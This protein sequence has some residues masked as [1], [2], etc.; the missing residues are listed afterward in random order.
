MI[1]GQYHLLL[2]FSKLLPGFPFSCLEFLDSVI[3]PVVKVIFLKWKLNHIIFL[4][5]TLHGTLVVLEKQF[6]LSF[7]LTFYFILGYSQLTI[8]NVVVSGEQ[9]SE[10]PI[11]IYSSFLRS[12]VGSL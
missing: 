8:E 9:P 1:T 4:L 2:E 3:Y 5:K 6:I 7:F 10:A 11:Y 12:Q